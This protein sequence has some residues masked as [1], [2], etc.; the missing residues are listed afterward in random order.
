MAEF[1]AAVFE[2]L[3]FLDAWVFL[4]V[5]AGMRLHF[6]PHRVSYPLINLRERVGYIEE[7]RVPRVAPP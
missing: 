7:R 6:S 2:A 5:V 4:L 3:D 1:V